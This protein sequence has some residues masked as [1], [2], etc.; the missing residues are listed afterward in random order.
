MPGNRE[1][2][3]GR[4]GNFRTPGLIVDHAAL[5]PTLLV[6]LTGE[7]LMNAATKI[8][9]ILVVAATAGSSPF[10]QTR[11]LNAVMREKLEHSQRILEAVVTSN[12]DQ[13]DREGRALARASQD[14]AWSV[15]Q[16][17]EY[18]RHS[19]A[20][21]RATRDLIEA[22]KL[23]DLEAASL[24][25]ISLSTSCVSCHRYIARSRTVTARP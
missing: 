1:N 7:E 25:F 14:P 10:A 4:L 9:A 12:W 5:A 22:A 8:L 13:L 21:L 24:G 23:R 18:V 19:D 2:F 16:M 20:F 15:L 11:P 17:P 6:A 3:R